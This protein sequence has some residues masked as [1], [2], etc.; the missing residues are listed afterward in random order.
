MQFKAKT[1]THYIFNYLIMQ[2]LYIINFELSCCWF[3]ALPLNIYS[4][5][6]VPCLPGKPQASSLKVLDLVVFSG[7]LYS[8]EFLL[9][10]PIFALPLLFLF[11]HTQLTIAVLMMTADTTA[12]TINMIE[13]SW[14]LG[15]LSP[16]PLLVTS[17]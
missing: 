10:R 9:L 11:Q 6:P 4:Q 16:C 8:T 12:M 2:L 17:S 3:F 7:L 14:E 5:I 13:V 1:F 15:P